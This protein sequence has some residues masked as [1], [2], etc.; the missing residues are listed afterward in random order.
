MIILWIVSVFLLLFLVIR[1]LKLW[2]LN[3]LDLDILDFL[4]VSDNSKL[5][6]QLIVVKMN[7]KESLILWR[8]YFAIQRLIKIYQ[9][10]PK[11]KVDRETLLILSHFSEF[12]LDKRKQGFSKRDVPIV[13][14]MVVL[15]FSSP[16]IFEIIR[17]VEDS[18]RELKWLNVLRRI[19]IKGINL[20]IKMKI[21]VLKDS[22]LDL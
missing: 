10:K 13:R 22:S 17:I 6:N 11:R 5:Q 21:K 3:F 7:E 9:E 8:I 20:E 14:M 18:L 2:I 15:P 4:R 19:F 12:L 16:E 1:E